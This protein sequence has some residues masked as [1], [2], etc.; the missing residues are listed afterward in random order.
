[1][2][3]CLWYS[4][5]FALDCAKYM[6][7]GGVCSMFK[8]NKQSLASFRMKRY[9]QP[10]CPITCSHLIITYLLGSTNFIWKINEKG[11]LQKGV[12]GNQCS[13]W[14]RLYELKIVWWPSGGADVTENIVSTASKLTL[15][16]CFCILSGSDTR[17]CFLPKDALT[18][19]TSCCKCLFISVG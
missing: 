19:V 11:S 10:V 5:S 17:W 4:T 15:L 12:Y 14:C 7:D 6:G 9:E 1:M 18:M 8:I 13:L 3:K 2:P 16:S